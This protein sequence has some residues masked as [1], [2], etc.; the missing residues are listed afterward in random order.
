MDSPSPPAA[1]DPQAV[2]N[3]QTGS[4]IQTAKTQAVLS[5]P[6][7]V[8]PY[9]QQTVTWGGQPQA[10]GTPTSAAP[11]ADPAA[12][13]W[14]QAQMRTNPGGF[15]DTG[16]DGI[17]YFNSTGADPG[18]MGNAHSGTGS[19]GLLSDQATVTQTLSPAQQKLLD[20]Q[21]GLSL[22]M[23]GIG[24]KGLNSIGNTLSTPVGGAS[25]QAAT[26]QAY[27]AYAARLDPQWRQAQNQQET[28]LRNQGVAPGGEAYDNAMR[29]FNQGK[30]DAY[31]QANLAAMSAAPQQQQMDI[32]G[33][34]ALLN[35]L[36]AIRTGS[37]VQTPQFQ[38]YQGSPVAPTNTLGAQQMAYQGGLNNYNAGVGQAN[39]F[40]SG[41]MSL[42]G[43]VGM[44][45]LMSDR[46]L[47]S[48]IRRI[49]THPSG[50]GIYE[51]DIFGH[52]TQG[53]MAD[54]VERVLPAAVGRIGPWFAVDY[55][56]L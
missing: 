21:Q 12:T 36:N 34:D 20:A 6:N 8:T 9:G 22:Q 31:S 51:Y 13:A 30:N 1:P 56:M 7:I 14:R 4:N 10:G 40:N 50:I 33:R 41:L 49:G 47:K 38:Q 42:A 17:P 26:D 52:R 5:N 19:A 11:A 27:K 24:Q 43:T 25:G 39:S 48:N 16:V 18:G 53:V 44:G 32:S 29:V 55:G 45:M 15:M 35:E 54:E 2:A 37:Q 3:A 46:R 28:Q 23:A